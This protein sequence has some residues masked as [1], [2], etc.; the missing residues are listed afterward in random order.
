MRGLGSYKP[1]AVL[2]EYS[3]GIHGLPKA[4]DGVQ[5]PGDS[6]FADGLPQNITLLSL[7]QLTES[8]QVLKLSIR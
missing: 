7:G 6:Q 1:R 3:V 4:I 2:F 8:L 5:C